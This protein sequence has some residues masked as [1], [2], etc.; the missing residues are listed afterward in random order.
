MEVVDDASIV[1][2]GNRHALWQPGMWDRAMRG[3]DDFGQTVEY[4]VRNPVAAELVDDVGVWPWT[5]A[6]Y[7][8]EA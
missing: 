5:W 2:H 8:E 7:M 6:W 1:A 3:A 4:I